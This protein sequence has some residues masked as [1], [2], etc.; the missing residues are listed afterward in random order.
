MATYMNVVILII[1]NTEIKVYSGLL[2]F[3]VRVKR[4]LKYTDKMICSERSQTPKRLLIMLDCQRLLVKKYQLQYFN[5][6]TQKFECKS[7]SNIPPSIAMFQILVNPTQAP[8]SYVPPPPGIEN[9]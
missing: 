5:M 3:C 9:P 6:S 8:A 7:V 2:K 4:D 1:F